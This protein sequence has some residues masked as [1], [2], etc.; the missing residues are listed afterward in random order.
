MKVP[1]NSIS[2][3]MEF[4]SAVVRH[5]KA[6]ITSSIIAALLWWLQGV[7]W[8]APR[9][10]V[11]W[12]V[13]LLGLL[14]ACYQAW[15]DEHQRLG[16]RLAALEKCLCDEYVEIIDRD[17]KSRIHATVHGEVTD[18]FLLKNIQGDER[19]LKLAISAWRDRHAKEVTMLRGI[20]KPGWS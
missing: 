4:V 20:S 6:F 10:W 15:L 3:I 19:V 12:S 2:S 7:G 5:W 17:F 8:L 18:D 11:V 13:A 1:S 14:V 16:E 9:H